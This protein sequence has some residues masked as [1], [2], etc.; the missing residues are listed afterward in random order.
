MRLFWAFQELTNG[1]PNGYKDSIQYLDNILLFIPYGLFFPCKK[2]W[3]NSVLESALFPITIEVCL[4]MFALGLAELD[5]VISNT[6][7]ALIGYLFYKFI[8][9][10]IQTLRG[11]KCSSEEG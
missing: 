7:G 6:L 1:D 4:Y 8:G 5:D 3:W 10:I 11:K 2:N 9:A